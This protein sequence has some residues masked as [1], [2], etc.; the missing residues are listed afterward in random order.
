MILDIY[1][2][3]KCEYRWKK[4][5]IKGTSR[6]TNGCPKCGHIYNEWV[7]ANEILWSSDR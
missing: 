1:R 7:N 4:L 6:A 3:M 2:C 5:H